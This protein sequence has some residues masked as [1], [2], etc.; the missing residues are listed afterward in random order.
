MSKEEHDQ[1]LDQF[2]F[3]QLGLQT[4][5]SFNP[6]DCH[7]EKDKAITTAM[8]MMTRNNPLNFEIEMNDSISE[9]KIDEIIKEYYTRRGYDI[10]SDGI[11]DLE[12]KKEGS[13]LVIAISH[14]EKENLIR[15]SVIPIKI[16]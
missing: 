16:I 10:E 8:A 2:V 1:T 4:K 9:G 5:K 6:D 15:V 12:A 14:S 3:E 11:S 7:D 13:H